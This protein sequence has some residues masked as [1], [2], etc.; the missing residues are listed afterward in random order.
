VN[1]HFGAHKSKQRR[2]IADFA[3]CPFLPLEPA[4]LGT[5]L[6][7][8]LLT[9]FL[10]LN[11]PNPKESAMSRTSQTKILA[12]F[13]SL[14]AAL[15]ADN[16]LF[17]ADKTA[18]TTP[19]RPSANQYTPY[20]SVTVPAVPKLSMYGTAPACPYSTATM[21]KLKNLGTQLGRALDIA[22][23][24]FSGNEADMLSKN[25][26][27]LLSGNSANVLSGNAPKVLSENTTPILSGNS[28]SLFS[29][30]KIEIHID[31]SGN[32]MAA[33][34]V[35]QPAS[36]RAEPNPGPSRKPRPR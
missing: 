23:D 35:A 26:A 2:G 19:N 9:S 33:G 30:I 31:N 24:L 28:F 8:V 4:A 17:A 15:V 22:A 10:T 5:I 29:N 12:V 34:A 11:A 14:T 13:L 32:T 1:G 25:K 20:S 21:E 6:K 3:W 16:R 36:R 7:D 27:A 18:T